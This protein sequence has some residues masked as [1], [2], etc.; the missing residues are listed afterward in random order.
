[1]GRPAEIREMPARLIDELMELLPK[2][3]MLALTGGEPL[4]SKRVHDLLKRFSAERY[5]DGAVTITTNGQLLR[6]NIL[7]DLSGTRIRQ[8]YVS[9]NAADDA[10]YEHVS[11]IPGGFTRVKNHLSLLMD[12]APR[13]A[14]RP[15]VIV[16][17]DRSMPSTATTFPKDFISPVASMASSGMRGFPSHWFMR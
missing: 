17:F 6:E 15:G 5:P 13:M 1:M 8:F 7:R 12:M 4:V 16:S 2:T 10:M 9:L 14:G 11:G 3:R